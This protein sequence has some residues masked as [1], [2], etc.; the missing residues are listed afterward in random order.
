[1]CGCGTVERGREANGEARRRSRS[2]FQ[3]V[4]P[5]LGRQG[6]GT[7]NLREWCLT[8]VAGIFVSA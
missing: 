2:R 5:A 1:M 4:Y 7:R 6:D 3:A 8:L